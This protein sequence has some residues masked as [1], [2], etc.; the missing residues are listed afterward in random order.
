MFCFSFSVVASWRFP[1]QF[2]K[3]SVSFIYCVPWSCLYCWLFRFTSQDYDW[4]NYQTNKLSSTELEM[5]ASM[6]RQQNEELR[7]TVIS[8]GLSASQIDNYNVSL[9]TSSDDT[10]TW[11]SCFP[12]VSL[13]P[14]CFLYIISIIVSLYSSRSWILKFF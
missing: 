6:K 3:V 5:L 12:P 4:K 14:Q 1:K 13:N 11:N 10:A 7:D 9:S 8:H 2:S